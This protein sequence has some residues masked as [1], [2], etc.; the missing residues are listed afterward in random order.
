MSLFAA[1]GSANDVDAQRGYARV[2]AIHASEIAYTSRQRRGNMRRVIR[3][4]IMQ[5]HQLNGVLPYRTLVR[6]FIHNG[7][8]A[9]ERAEL[10]YAE[11]HPS[12]ANGAVRAES[13]QSVVLTQMWWRGVRCRESPNDVRDF[14][15]HQ[16]REVDR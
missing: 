6:D 1:H 14:E 13:T 2:V 7:K 10:F 4:E 15:A 11:V 12:L 8:R 3:P 5:R 16:F 9:E